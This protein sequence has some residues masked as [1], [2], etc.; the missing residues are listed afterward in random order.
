VIA[1]IDNYDSF[2]YNLV[3][4]LA[5]QGLEPLVFKNDAVTIPELID[6]NFQGFLISPGPGHPREAGISREVVDQFHRTH[7][8]L[9]VCL[10]HQVIAEYFGAKVVG[11][12]RILHGHTSPIYHLGKTYQG[13]KQPFQATRYHSLIVENLPESLEKTAWSFA[14]DGREEIMGLRHR[15]FAVE[16][17]QFHPES[18]L[19]EGGEALITN[20]FKD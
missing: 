12:S 6:G 14:A 5:K 8:I 3:Q 4:I 2:T 20:F 17:V 11:A 19:S 16:G 10:G 18:I 9:G 1:V 15:E 7:K 13:L